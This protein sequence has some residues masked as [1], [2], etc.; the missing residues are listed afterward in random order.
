MT[1]T[2]HSAEQWRWSRGKFRLGGRAGRKTRVSNGMFAASLCTLPLPLGGLQDGG[3]APAEGPRE[4]WNH[5]QGLGYRFNFCRQNMLRKPTGQEVGSH[6]L[7]QRHLGQAIRAI[8]SNSD[9]SHKWSPSD[10]GRTFTVLAPGGQRREHT[11]LT[12]SLGMRTIQVPPILAL[13]GFPQWA[14][15]CSTDEQ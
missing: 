12:E 10:Y 7:T 8:C 3:W 1:P 13:R 15:Y 11:Q 2:S 14:H 9:S 6:V 4:G 5:S